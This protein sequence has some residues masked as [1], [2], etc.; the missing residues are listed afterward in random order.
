MRDSGGLFLKMKEK[1]RFRTMRKD[2]GGIFIRILRITQTGPG[3][4]PGV[5]KKYLFSGES[6]YK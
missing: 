5:V 6:I 4:G 3:T 1:M 2:T